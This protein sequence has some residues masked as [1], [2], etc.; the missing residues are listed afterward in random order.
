MWYFIDDRSGP[1]N[2][3]HPTYFFKDAGLYPVAMVVSNKYGCTDS[4][5]RVIEVEVDFTFYVPNSFTPNNDNLNE[6]FQPVIRGLRSYDLQI[7][8]RWGA[9]IFSSNVLENSWDGTF[10]GRACKSDT[11][12]W[13]ITIVT[14]KG[15][16]KKYTGHVMLYR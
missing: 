1:L 15:E 8:D 7:F 11:Y 6:N 13:K 16:Q 4:V 9:M 2:A 14:N 3:E 12:V 10:K 5:V